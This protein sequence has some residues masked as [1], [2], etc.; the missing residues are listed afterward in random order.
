VSF[1]PADKP[2]QVDVEE[3]VTE[4]TVE[5]TTVYIDVLSG[6]QGAVGP[7]GP[8][9]PDGPQGIQGPQGVPG[10]DGVGAPV[11]GQVAKMTSGTITI[12]TQGV[13]Q[14]TGLTAVLDG[15]AAGISLG[16]VDLFAI[17]NTSGFTRRL[18]ISA[19]YDASMAGSTKQLGL[20]LAINGVID[21]DTECRA[22][23]GLPGAIAKL[24]TAWII[25]LPDGQE[26]AMRVA[27]FT[28][29]NAIQF[30]RGRIVATSVAGFGPQGPQGPTG[31]T[32]PSAPTLRFVFDQAVP[33]S[34]WT[35][36]H[37]L[38]GFPAVAVVDSANTVVY[39]M[40]EYVD[41]TQVTV[42]FSAPFSGK[43]FLT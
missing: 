33:S 30:Q 3:T 26:V 40:I 6:I 38:G 7:Q 13:Y 43:A 36:S 16:T 37:T 12:A 32:G 41:S 18:K 8:I 42:T 28:G 9:G 27:N 20:A 31:P 21:L 34:L 29:T 17:K 10:L 14:P 35:I 39:G 1:S 22:T 24:N 15:E 4:V 23:T 19:S 11:F 25:D 5:E 2:N